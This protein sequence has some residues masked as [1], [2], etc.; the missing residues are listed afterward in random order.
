MG[1]AFLKILG[2][3]GVMLIRRQGYRL[4]LFLLLL[5]VAGLQL[6]LMAA[7]D[8]RPWTVK[9]FGA[10]AP[11]SGV[12]VRSSSDG[13][14]VLTAGHVLEGTSLDDHPTVV[15]PDGR[16]LPVLSIRFLQALDLAEIRV[17]WPNAP[18]PFLSLEPHAGGPIWLGGYPQET[19]RFWL[20]KGPSDEQGQSA[21][22]RPGGYALFHGASSAIGLSGAGLYNERGQLV[23]IHG[24]ADVLRTPSGQV[25][26]S[27]VGLGIPIVFWQRANAGDPV[28]QASSP[29]QDQLLQVSWL[30]SMGRFASA[31]N[32]LDRLRKRYPD[33]RRVLQRR[34]GVLMADRSFDKALQDLDELLERFPNDAAILVN[35]GNA[36][37]GLKRPILALKSYEAALAKE[38]RLVWGY[39]NKAKAQQ[40]LGKW[41]DAKGS[42]D[43][44]IRLSP[45]D[46]VA[47]RERA[48]VHHKLGLHKAALVD[49]DLLVTQ[50]TSDPEVWARRGL[51]RGEI[52][53]L[54]GSIDDLTT[55]IELQPDDPL[56]R[57]NR[58]ATLARLKR[59]SEAESDFE[60][61]R[62]RLPR[63]P[64]L[65]ANLG[66]ALFARGEV[67]K[68]C[69]F[70]QEATAL[71]VA[72]K[73]GRWSED[74]RNQCLPH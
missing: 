21:S 26:K 51:V 49:L 43:R 72:W 66:E 30:E 13:A 31:L 11:G 2:L 44:A 29:L 27:G 74:Y 6:P 62:Q 60:K 59:W 15:L 61:A 33:D 14:L 4:P 9:V 71:G 70:A 5:Q 73:Q 19:L 38:P 36:L 25:F 45:R 37:L 63:H 12:V 32:L 52:G 40:L 35:R 41:K 16:E 34:A 55:A 18:Y 10:S 28:D 22:A 46:P 53:D 20:R 48:S 1:L 47:L 42:L 54:V 57:L 3:T 8:P 50:R 69:F 58:G 67:T 64:V 39:V 7:P 17:A 56:H 68:A 65:L 23:A 24:E